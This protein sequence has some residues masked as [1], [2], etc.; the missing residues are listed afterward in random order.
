MQD[1]INTYIIGNGW[2]GVFIGLSL[3]GMGYWRGASGKVKFSILVIDATIKD[4]IDNG[5][6]KTRRKLVDGKWEEEILRH[7]E[8][9]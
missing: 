7:D 3:F 5:Y 4:M 1:F 2:A 9:V 8:E 6:V